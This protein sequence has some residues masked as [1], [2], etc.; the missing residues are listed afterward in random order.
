MGPRVFFSRRLA[1]PPQVGAH[2]SDNRAMRATDRLADSVAAQMLTS[3]SP[4]RQTQPAATGDANFEKMLAIARAGHWQPKDQQKSPVKLSQI[5]P[6][7]APPQPAAAPAAVRKPP[8]AAPAAIRKPPAAAPAA[9][10]KPPTTAWAEAPDDAS[11]PTDS[12]RGSPSAAQP[13]PPPSTMPTRAA[14]KG[15][16]VGVAESIM[17]DE[18]AKR[19]DDAPSFE[20]MAMAVAA[21]DNEML[22]S[23]HE[24]APHKLLDAS[25]RIVRAHPAARSTHPRACRHRPCKPRRS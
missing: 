24:R 7:M 18:R 9:I 22:R 6:A 21:K 13:L 2:E 3:M 5:A 23:I 17:A 19:P 16:K 15:Y 1:T 11:T 25:E 12:D 20:A 14:P 8:A 4:T 10:R